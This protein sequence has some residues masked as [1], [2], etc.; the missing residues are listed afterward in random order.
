M[1][2]VWGT[3]QVALAVAFGVVLLPLLL[4]AAP[5]DG[6]LVVAGADRPLPS[7]CRTRQA[8]GTPCPGCGL[9][10]GL[11]A[12]ADGDVPSGRRH[13]PAAPPLLVLLL[14]QVAAR[15]LLARLQLRGR[16]AL[17]AGVADFAFHATVL[18]P[19]VG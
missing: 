8:T 17:L 16:R 10:R 2:T 19:L 11:V 1:T 15:P 7:L 12:C 5:A 18:L 13:H 9:T 3:S 6:T 14:L 4:L